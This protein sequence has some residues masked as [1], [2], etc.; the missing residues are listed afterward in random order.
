METASVTSRSSSKRANVSCVRCSDRK[1]KCDRQSPCSACVKHNVQCVVR[2]LQP[3]RKR[4]KRTK[5]EVLNDRLK[6]YESLLEEQG[7]DTTD[8]SETS[9][10]HQPSKFSHLEGTAADDVSQLPTPASTIFETQ[11]N[12][13]KTQLLHGQ[14]RSK[15]VDK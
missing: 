10:L 7:I 15:L 3:P 2:S 4:A 13:T 12:V 11:Q 9:Q 6:R 14:G 1:V 8:L 5:N